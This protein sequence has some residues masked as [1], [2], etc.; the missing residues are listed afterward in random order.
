MIE[1]IVRIANIGKFTECSP[2]GDVTFR[3]LTLIYGPNGH[4]KTTLCDILRSLE[5]GDPACIQGRKT[6]GSS[7]EPDVHIRHSGKSAR[8]TKSKW[9][10]ASPGID[11]YDSTFVNENVHAGDYVDIETRK[12]L[13]HVIVG[14]EGVQLARKLDNIDSEVRQSNKTVK[15][16][17]EEVA[18][19]L[20]SGCTLDDFLALTKDAS[21]GEKIAAKQSEL[22]AQESAAAIS[23]TASLAT[24]QLPHVPVTLDDTCGKVLSDISPEVEKRVKEHIK[25]HLGSSGE[26]WVADGLAHTSAGTCP[27]CAQDLQS[28]TLVPLYSQ[29]FSEAYG[30]LKDEIAKL[31]SSTTSTLADSALLRVR[32]QLSDNAKLH[33]FWSAFDVPG[34]PE[35]PEDAL[36][37]SLKQLRSQALSRIDSKSAAPLE[38]EAPSATYLSAH[39]S[40]EE[41]RAAFDVYAQAVEAINGRIE[42]IKA[43][44]EE[45]DVDGLQE[46]LRQLRA[47]ESR[48]EEGTAAA[49]RAYV[50][51][52]AEN[53]SL[54][55]AKSAAKENLDK[56][57]EEVFDNYQAEIN[58]ILQGFQA[59]FRIGSTR[60]RYDG[61]SVSSTYRIVI[62]DVEV[63]LGGPKKPASEPT[64][65][66][67]LSGG[68]RSALALAFFLAKVRQDSNIS[69]R[70]VV[71]DDPFN[72]QDRSRRTRT[73]QHI[74]K[75]LAVARQVVVLSHD[76]SFLRDIWKAVPETGAVRSLQLFRTGE[77]DTHINE[78][79]IGEEFRGDYFENHQVLSSYCA[80]GV[81]SESSSNS[82]RRSVAR[83]IRPLLE[84]YLEYKLPGQFAE[85]DS[86]GEMAGAV[87]RA[88]VTSPLAAAKRIE[89]DLV[90]LNDFSRRYHH[91]DN[92][93]ADKEP[94]DDGELQ[95]Y[96]SQALG[97]VGG[98]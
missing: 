44:T 68:D 19:A 61:G 75:L 86:L 25:T 62:N 20:P 23:T 15:G 21:V 72:S 93:N 60:H 24:I 92:P 32:K 64:F 49:C 8:F 42:S 70:T 84:K 37:A 81:G 39:A 10:E 53:A 91:K 73:R 88:D 54:V 45:G 11:L 26:K 51:T 78:W 90:D 89:E 74:V 7:S 47:I 9:S 50:E 56:Y 69:D 96:A 33:D 12:R 71:L 55:A 82:R 30:Q 36:E 34:L 28:S 2:N 59:G 48:H 57:S 79:N 13:Y 27:F 14:A 83:A 4:G 35:P 18:K 17:K 80:D 31:R 94:I 41:M 97:I 63:N 5:S 29:F 22:T 67:T 52:S 1:K 85:N 16:K 43:A 6:L 3:K 76:P 66:N 58:R 87:R 77:N 38:T 40:F 46:D 98:F 65:R 95:S